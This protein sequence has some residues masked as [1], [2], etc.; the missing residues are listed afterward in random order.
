MNNIIFNALLAG[1]FTGLGYYGIVSHS[2]EL[3]AIGAIGFLI[4]FFRKVN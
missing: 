4:C 1:A 2:T 3:F